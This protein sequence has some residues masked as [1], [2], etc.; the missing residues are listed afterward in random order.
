M[1]IDN[2]CKCPACSDSLV[3]DI[4]KVLL[5]CPSCG[6]TCDIE[7]YE[8]SLR[9]KKRPPWAAAPS[10][11]DIACPNC[12]VVLSPGVQALTMTCPCCGGFFQD[13]T[14]SK[15]ESIADHKDDSIDG[16]KPDRVLPFALGREVFLKAFQDS[17]GKDPI[18]KDGFLQKISPEN[19]RPVYLPFLVYD[20]KVL[21]DLS[22]ET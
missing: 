11:E 10:E 21:A 13:E 12:G 2:S 5:C 3:F 16:V 19:V 1:N 15:N 8:R 7:K 6:T 20:L 9:V 14:G 18:V 4:E 17:C 22:V